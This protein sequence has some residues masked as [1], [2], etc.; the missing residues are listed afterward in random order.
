MIGSIDL[1]DVIT[2]AGA[3]WTIGKA[4]APYVLDYVVP[5]IGSLS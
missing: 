5:A 2:I 4:L 1:D 3:V